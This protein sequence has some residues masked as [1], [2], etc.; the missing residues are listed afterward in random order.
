MWKVKK[1]IWNCT[2]IDFVSRQYV[3]IWDI[4]LALHEKLK[5]YVESQLDFIL[6]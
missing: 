5:I 2:M 1:P 3:T 4:D 6:H